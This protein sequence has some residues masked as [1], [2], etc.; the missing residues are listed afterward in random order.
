MDVVQGLTQNAVINTVNGRISISADLVENFPH[1][2]DGAVTEELFHF[3]QLRARDLLGGPI[4]G[5]QRRA[6][7]DELVH[8][9]LSS[10][11]KKH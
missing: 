1:L 5:N 6:M 8:L 9:M 3:Q 7:E 2:I 10:G 4:T 11:F